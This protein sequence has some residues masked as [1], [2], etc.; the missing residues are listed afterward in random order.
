METSLRAYHRKDR[1]SILIR[2][3][4]INDTVL[5][6]T[7][8]NEG[9]QRS[10][11]LEFSVNGKILPGLTVSASG[12]LGTH[13]QIYVD[14]E[15]F[16]QV[17]LARSL[18]LRARANYQIGAVDS[19]QLMVNRQGKMLMGQGYREAVA[20]ANVSWRHTITPRLNLVLN[21]TDLFDSN[22]INTI[23][24]TD[25]LRDT[26]ERRFDGRIV[27]LGLS[28]RFGGVTGQQRPAGGRQ[29]AGG[30]DGGGM[31]RGGMRGGGPGR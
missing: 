4:F 24:D 8:E 10:G 20:T 14:S 31:E 16:E 1:D 25:I 19:V 21:V 2:R 7:R 27:Y 23:V 12:N 30:Q 29:R 11:G 17:R 3:Y 15:G 5:L 13:E 22:T 18:S 9:T 26:S 28:Y 6:T